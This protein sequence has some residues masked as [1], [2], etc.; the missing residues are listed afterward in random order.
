MSITANLIYDRT[1][2]DVDRW[3]VLKNKGYTAMTTAEKAEWNAG[4]RGAYTPSVDYN[5]VETAVKALAEL[6]NTLGYYTDVTT[7]TSWA[8]T[9]IPAQEDLNRYLNNI[10]E[11]RSALTVAES[12]PAVPSDMSGLTW[13]EANDI[14]KILTDVEDA[15][16][17]IQLSFWNSGEIWSGER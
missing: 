7:K 16:K 14:E 5:R 3:A 1:Q 2:A 15:V 10:T 11:I 12:T 8:L 17:R 13:Q 9:D 4:M 6:L